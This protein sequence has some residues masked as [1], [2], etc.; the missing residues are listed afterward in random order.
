MADGTLTAEEQ[1]QLLRD[2]EEHEAREI[3]P[4]IHEK[5]LKLAQELEA[6]LV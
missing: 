4:A 5:Y 6:C 1:K 2:F 3:G